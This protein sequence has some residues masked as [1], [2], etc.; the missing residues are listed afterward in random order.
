MVSEQTF[1]SLIGELRHLRDAGSSLSVLHVRVAGSRNDIFLG[2]ADGQLCI[3]FWAPGVW[4]WWLK[5]KFNRY[6]AINKLAVTVEHWGKKVVLRTVVGTNEFEVIRHVSQ[7]FRTLYAAVPG[8]YGLQ[9]QHWG[10][11]PADHEASPA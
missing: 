4:G 3:D 2:N 1:D 8:T 9:V 11:R 10:W 7:L 5:R 6:C